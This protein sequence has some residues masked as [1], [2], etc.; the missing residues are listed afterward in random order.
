MARRN[1]F[2]LDTR[3]FDRAIR[4]SP[5]AVNRAAAKVLGEI[6]EDWVRE[7]VDIA[8][9][10]TGNLRQTIEAE[11]LN[12]G[13]K[14]SVEIRGNAIRNQF[15]YGYYIHEQ[16][17]GGRSVSGTKEFLRVSAEENLD[18]WSGWLNDEIER[19]LRGVGW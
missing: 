18:K 11:V 19:E 7:A 10:D 17:A 14:G 3:E 4:L 15:N 2:T 13:S 1:N 5:Q 9:I 12:A 16:N 6:R 8:P